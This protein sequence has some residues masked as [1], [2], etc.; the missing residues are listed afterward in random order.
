MSSLAP[1]G[2]GG[3][4]R[5]APSAQPDA[6]A[7]RRG[8]PDPGIPL[9]VIALPTVALW[10]VGIG[11]WAF[12]AWLLLGAG[13]SAW[14][15]IPLHAVVNFTMFTVLHDAT[16]HAVSRHTWINEVFG[17]LSV[18]FVASYASFPLI[19][20]IHIEHHRNTNEPMTEDPDAWTS[21]GPWWQLPFRWATIDVWY[22]LFYLPRAFHWKGILDKSERPIIRRPRTEVIE[23]V[24]L[25]ALSA[26]VYGALIVSGLGWYLLV[27][28]IIPQRIALTALAWWFDWLP[29]HGLEATHKQDRYRATRVRV[30]M[31]W[32]LTP[33]LLYQN[34]HLVH[35]LHPAI[36]FYRYI[37]AWK[38]NEDGYLDANVAITSAWGKELTPEEYREWRHITHNLGAGSSSRPEFR[39]LTVDEVLPLTD[40]AVSL[41]FTIP[42]ELKEEFAFVPGQHLTLEL[43][44]D[45]KR[46]RRTY[47]ICSSVDSGRARIAI[48]RI[49]GGAVSHQLV[50]SARRG[51]V[52]DVLPPS[53]RFT[54]D[55]APGDTTTHYVAIAA[56]SGITP[57]LA[58]IT[59]TLERDEN[60]RFT[61]LY[62]NKSRAQTMFADELTTLAEKFE[63]R[64]RIVHFL[65]SGK[66]PALDGELET[67]RMRRLQPREIMECA[68]PGSGAINGWYLCG[69]Q[70]LIDRATEE[71]EAAGIDPATIHSELFFA[72]AP[73]PTTMHSVVSSVTARIDGELYNGVSSG[74]E[75]VLDTVLQTG[76]DAPYACM[77]GACGTCRAKLLGGDVEM[78]IRY[79]L[80]DEEVADG[81]ILTCQARPTTHQVEVDYDQ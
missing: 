50:S 59:T 1:T 66:E 47:S 39:K 11:W 51:D 77:G 9:P 71:L 58:M 22:V 26:V 68:E 42:E 30:G 4:A 24:F 28:Y 37:T 48:K 15:T 67:V 53:G 5:S 13:V 17:R 38:R 45:G 10:A 80:T 31:E 54:L 73:P 79:A 78:D 34:Y 18:P 55:H 64:L 36:P 65:T 35:H 70:D 69:P 76:G 41:T 81:Y 57:I 62:S 3:T 16:H 19:R 14:I 61:L 6:L 75:T 56:G 46:Q 74:P 25:L 43:T 21:H 33:T 23:S 27:M 29:H 72:T 60:A 52:L 32:L 44:V 7:P 40:D 2:A 63:G 49:P 8:V 20:Y 12:V